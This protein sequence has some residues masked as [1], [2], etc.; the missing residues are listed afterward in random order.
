MIT[1]N[2]ITIITLMMIIMIMMFINF[3]I[4][5]NSNFNMNKLSPFECG[6]N[7]MS[8]MHPP[9]SMNFYLMTILFLMFDI[10]ITILMPFFIM[11]KMCNMKIYML[12]LFLF[13]TLMTLGLFNEWNQNILNWKM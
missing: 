8:I 13:M 1:L 9:F 10:E 6:Y 3:M 11:I 7:T 5:K 12:T 2:L 4:S